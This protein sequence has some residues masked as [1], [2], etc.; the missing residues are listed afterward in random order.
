MSTR[1]TRSSA[2]SSNRFE[3][4]SI[5]AFL[6]WGSLVYTIFTIYGSLVP[7]EYS[8]LPLEEAFARFRQISFLDLGIGS[9]A[10]WV[11]NLLLFVPL[12]FLWTG[13]L[14]HERS[15]LVRMLSSLFVV[16]GAAL[17]SLCIEFTQ[18]YFPQRTV[19]QN[20]I[21]AE[22][23]G[24][25]IGMVA[26]GL[27]G[28]R[29]AHWLEGWKSVKSHLAITQRLT[30]VYL[31]L[32]FGYSLLPLD[33]TI[34]PVEVYHKFR[35]GKFNLLPFARLSHNPVHALY[36]LASDSLLWAV[37]AFFWRW[38]DKT[39]SMRVWTIM[40]G[41]AVL[42]EFLQ[43]FVY[44]RVSDITDIFTAA[45][46]AGAGVWFAS[47][48]D[49]NATHHRP[50]GDTGFAVMPL[51]LAVVWAGLIMIV[52][53]YPYEFRTDGASL[54]ERLHRFL[55]SVPFQAYYFGSEYR[56]ITE[57]MHKVLFF[58]PFGLFLGW[59]VS[60]LRYMWR[61]Y[62]T[63]LSLV[64]IAGFALFIVAGRLIQP[65]KSPD[66]VDSFL[67]F[68]GG[69]LGFFV[70]GF[71]RTRWGKSRQEKKQVMEAEP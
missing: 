53:W 34:S 30:L 51:V 69:A 52:F 2:D 32:L 62:A 9:R 50:V 71:M 49:K 10:D 66:I 27:A 41:A 12:T 6:I 17:L 54:R 4:R 20:D 42:L 24:G 15:L 13:A 33:L 40:M 5:R 1:Q 55:G 36:E 29:F 25:I 56:A 59:F 63:W 7:L 65:G 47:I 43:V 19:S 38:S 67:Q 46:G 70:I 61:G 45:L 28:Q 21:L 60:R 39:T 16:V 31:F 26:W 3:G 22:M 11:A 35:E 8:Y 14:S 48:L 44:S 64:L 37:P 18:L 23:L 68:V 58:I 57:V